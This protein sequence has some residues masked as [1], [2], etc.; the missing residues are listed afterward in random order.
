MTQ[1]GSAEVNA[2]WRPMPGKLTLLGIAHESGGI[3]ICTAALLEVTHLTPARLA[4]LGLSR[5]AAA[6]GAA[7]GG[8]QVWLQA[9]RKLHVVVQDRSSAGPKNTRAL[10]CATC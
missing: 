6:A 3:R 5:A 8:S 10:V 1:G 7:A 2:G 4:E 9:A